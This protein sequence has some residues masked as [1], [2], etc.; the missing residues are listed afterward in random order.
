MDITK[1]DSIVRMQRTNSGLPSYGVIGKN[2]QV[3]GKS[4]SVLPARLI[5]ICLFSVEVFYTEPIKLNMGSTLERIPVRGDGQSRDEGRFC[6]SGTE[7]N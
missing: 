6:M 3:Y 7:Q 4:I 2:P 5:V 1:E